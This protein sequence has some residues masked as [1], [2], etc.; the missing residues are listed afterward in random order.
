MTDTNLLIVP[1]APGSVIRRFSDDKINAAVNSALAGIPEGQHAALFAVA[2]LKGAKVGVAWKIDGHFSV[3]GVLE[4]P[5]S[6]DLKGEL[7]ARLTI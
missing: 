5:W 7:A 4:K 1:E 2:D 3:V 6:G